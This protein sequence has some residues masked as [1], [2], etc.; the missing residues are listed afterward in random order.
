M[1][2]TGL[3]LD[4]DCPAVQQLRSAGADFL[5]LDCRQKNEYD[6]V[7][8][9]GAVLIPIEEISTRLGELEPH[10][11]RHIVVHCHHGGRSRMVTE[12][13]RQQ[14]FEQVQNMSGGIDAWAQHVDPTLP[15]Y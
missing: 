1:S 8:I 11:Q 3:P 13:L 10:R 15:R 5:L 12:W 4:I 9:Q 6:L 14:G 2:E 7:R